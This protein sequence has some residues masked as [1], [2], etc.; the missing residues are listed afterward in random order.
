MNILLLTDISVAGHTANH[1]CFLNRILNTVAATEHKSH[2]V[3]NAM[4]VARRKV[5]IDLYPIIECKTYVQA[6]P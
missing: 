6:T 2:R 3:W 4:R 5:F 1:I